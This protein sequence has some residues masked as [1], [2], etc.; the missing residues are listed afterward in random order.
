MKIMAQEIFLRDVANH[1]MTVRQDTP[2][3]RHLIFRGPPPNSWNLWFEIVTW[4]G[5]LTIHGDMGSWTFS[6]F[7]DMF[8]FFRS[9]PGELRI[10]PSYWH[11]KIQSES[12]FEGPA[13]RFNADTY[14]ASVLESLNG[15]DLEEPKKAAVIAALEDEVFGEEDETTARRALADFECEGFT[16]SDSWE[17]TGHGYTY[18]FLWCLY[19]IVWGI[20][21]YDSLK[22]RERGAA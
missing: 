15:Y 10:N 13:K 18:H 11:E 1:S 2:P 14:R 22:E 12:R 20:Q 21:Q 6:R 17:I 16:F 5:C 3:Y 4:A 8:D 9:R 7:D 19:A